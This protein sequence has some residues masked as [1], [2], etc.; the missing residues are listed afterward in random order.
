MSLS[1]PFHTI[2]FLTLSCHAAGERREAE[3]NDYL[4]ISERLAPT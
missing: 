1:V 2:M 3:D 4:P